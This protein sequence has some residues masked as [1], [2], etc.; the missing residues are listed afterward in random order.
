MFKIV[1]F[2]KDQVVKCL[3]DM[4]LTYFNELTRK[5]KLNIHFKKTVDRFGV[6]PICTKFGYFSSAKWVFAFHEGF[7]SSK[8]KSF[9]QKS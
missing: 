5:E 9:A 1:F 4:H 2:N 6:E 7:S 8:T 3:F